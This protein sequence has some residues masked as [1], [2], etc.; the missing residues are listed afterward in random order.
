MFALGLINLHLTDSCGSWTQNKSQI[1][2]PKPGISPGS[3]P[4]GQEYGKHQITT[5]KVL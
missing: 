2:D 4:N 3:V 1:V 5:T